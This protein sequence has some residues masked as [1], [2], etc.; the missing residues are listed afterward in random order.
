[1]PHHISGWSVD[2]IRRTVGHPDGLSLEFDGVPE[3]SNFSILSIKRDENLPHLRFLAL[4]RL[5][6]KAY[7]QC[8]QESLHT[9]DVPRVK[10]ALPTITMRPRRRIA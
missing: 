4:I 1:M 6:V 3:G 2:L 10:T 7:R 9:P 8:Y 5:G